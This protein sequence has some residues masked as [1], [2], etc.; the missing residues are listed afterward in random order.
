MPSETFYHQFEQGLLDDSEDYILWSGLYEML[1]DN[2]QQL[3]D[4]APHHQK[5]TTF[6]H[7]KHVGDSICDSIEPSLADVLL[8]IADYQYSDK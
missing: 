8:E 3:Y 4:N 6:P 7:H 2:Q 5:V 1:Q